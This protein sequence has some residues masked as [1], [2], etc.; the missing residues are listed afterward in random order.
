[1]QNTIGAGDSAVAAGT[2]TTLK[3]GT[4]LYQKDVFMELIPKIKLTAI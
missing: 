4:A 1:M 2:A 3:P